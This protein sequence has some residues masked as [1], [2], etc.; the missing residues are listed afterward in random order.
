MS[1]F[2]LPGFRR[3]APIQPANA[4]S[5]H[6]LRYPL[7]PA[8]RVAVLS[9]DLGSGPNLLSLPG[10]TVKQLESARPQALAGPLRDM[11]EVASLRELGILRLKSLVYPLVVFTLETD[12]RLSEADH[13]RLWRWFR[14]PV[15]EQVR[16]ADGRLL[17]WES[18]A[19][20]GLHLAE[21]APASL[22]DLD[23]CQDVP[24]IVS[25]A[26]AVSLTRVA[27]E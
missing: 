13:D 17:A 18:E 24:S 10:W 22:Y 20:D 26:S 11:E 23:L 9:L 4:S 14:L 7:D 27:A 8:P 19:R 25:R 1:F 2:S 3:R 16:A 15:F 5:R 21:D 6:P 12:A